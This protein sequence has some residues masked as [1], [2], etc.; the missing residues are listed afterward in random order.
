MCRQSWHFNWQGACEV[1]VVDCVPGVKDGVNHSQ[2]GRYRRGLGREWYPLC[3]NDRVS[4][5]L[6]DGQL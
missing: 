1:G 2:Q 3:V 4:G 6:R 5:Q